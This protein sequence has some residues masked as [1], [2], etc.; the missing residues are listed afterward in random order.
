V[1]RKKILLVDDTA[2]VTA[3]EKVVIGPGYDYVEARDGADAF[4][5]ALTHHPDLVLMD[6]N[7]PGTNGIEGLRQLKGD[8]ATRDIP[9]IIVTTHRDEQVVSLCRSLGCADFLTKPIGR[10][11]LNELIR[12]HVGG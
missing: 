1:S 3:L 9:V 12:K 2:T 5:K 8:Q 6:L 10:A 11:R 7:M 4:Q